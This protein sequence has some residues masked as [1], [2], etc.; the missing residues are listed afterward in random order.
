[1]AIFHILSKLLN[2]QSGSLSPKLGSLTKE[3]PRQVWRA[4]Y[5]TL[6][7]AI[8]E[9]LVY[10]PAPIE[11]DPE[12]SEH[13]GLLEDDE[14]FTSKVQQ[15]K[16]LKLVETNYES[17]LMRET[18]FPK[19][20]E[21]NVEVRD[22]V[23]NVMSNWRA[24]CGPSWTDREL[25]EGG[26]TSI[27]R[28]TL[29]V[30][31]RAATKTFHSPQILRH[32]F[33]VHAYLSDFDLAFK[34]LDSYLGIMTKG[35]ARAEKSGDAELDLDSD[36]QMIRF[37]AEAVRVACRYGAYVAA[38]RALIL[39][40]TLSK[41]LHTGSTSSLG[42]HGA[43]KQLQRTF[44]PATN[45][46]FEPES[47]AL[48]LR[49]IGMALANWSRV[50]YEAASRAVAQELGVANLEQALQQ[51]L[52]DSECTETL[53]TMAV[54]VAETRQVPTAIALVRRALKSDEEA[55]SLAEPDG[56]S[57]S[58]PG[59]ATTTNVKREHAFTRIRKMLPVWHLLAQL[60]S[61]CEE[62]EAAANACQMGIQSFIDLF[63]SEGKYNS[64]TL[65]E[66]ETSFTANALQF[67]AVSAGLLNHY[68][69]Q[70][71]LELQMTSVALLELN[72]GPSVALNASN[73]LLALYA[74]L[75][76]PVKESEGTHPRGQVNGAP[77]KS[78][79]GTIR[80]IFG[81]NKNRGLAHHPAKSGD[82]TIDID[83]SQISRPDTAIQAPSIQVTSHG[84]DNDAA[85]ATEK[86]AQAET[87]KLRRKT[88]GSVRSRKS[89]EPINNGLDE[90]SE[91][92][93]T[94]SASQPLPE[95][96]HNIPHAK[97]PPPAGHATQPP[98]QDT[99][100]PAPAPAE[101]SSS[102]ATHFSRVQEQRQKSSLLVKIWLFIARLYRAASQPEDAQDALEEALRVI[103]KLELEVAS[104]DASVKRMRE[105]GWGSASSIDDL[106]ADAYA[107]VQFLYQLSKSTLLTSNSVV[108][109]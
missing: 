65:Q 37:V 73:D 58:R 68:E 88:P 61:A 91:I 41:W 106:W 3:S 105:R 90:K 87:G 48:A 94:T 8:H 56:I 17:L 59:T 100:L 22:F 18:R 99:R 96:P 36:D 102:L 75:Y 54:L 97:Q 63:A 31:Y 7:K 77:P 86:H 101:D 16:D 28:R 70:T 39:G 82:G 43:E 72:E 26:A 74:Q 92:K 80:S 33:T 62:F 69:K 81:R 32:L 15:R 53:Y 30:L 51:G 4:Y 45:S 44:Q 57:T 79:H 11:R 85:A 108:T 20:E 14:F 12:V 103:E 46:R 109:C 40:A 24:L 76:G 38:E 55:A 84:D 21:S 27:S 34:S 1:M 89:V 23:E 78:A 83:D 67:T 35:K 13:R 107:E 66:E 64:V 60:L 98:E 47:T 71:L 29:D 19:A 95:V 10:H 93:Q 50:T 5:T 6:T 104:V 25:E 9:G 42:D 49:A 2:T 52:H